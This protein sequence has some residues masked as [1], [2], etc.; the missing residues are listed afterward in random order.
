MKIK[1]TG[2]GEVMC[3]DMQLNNSLAIEVFNL[4]KFHKRK[5]KVYR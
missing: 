5:I 4:F 3:S 2:N 1:L